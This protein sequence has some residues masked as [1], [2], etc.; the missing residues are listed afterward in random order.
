MVRNR[1]S[2]GPEGRENK[3]IETRPNA[4]SEAVNVATAQITTFV[5]SDR[6]NGS[7]LLAGRSARAEQITDPPDRPDRAAVGP[8]LL[9]EVTHV[10]VEHAVER[11]RYRTVVSSSRVT[12][13]PAGRT[14]Y[15]RISFSMEVTGTSA[16]S[17]RTERDVGRTRMPSDPT[18]SA[19]LAVP[20]RLRTART[21]A[22]SS[23]GANGLG[24]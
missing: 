5:E 15:S 18:S 19:G 21:H 16:P 10:D 1:K 3:T 14:R 20:V 4:A 11:R 7:P 2:D 8:E 23:A 6:V 13:R 22:A 9:A 24:R 17:Q 12:T